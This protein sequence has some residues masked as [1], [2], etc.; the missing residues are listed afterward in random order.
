MLMCDGIGIGCGTALAFADAGCRRLCLGDVNTKGLD[1]TRS[2]IQ[3]CYRDADVQVV[4]VDISNE[5]SVSA[6][7]DHCVHHLGRIDYAVF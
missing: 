6:F 2:L 1:K 7:V 3:T 4:R 5:A